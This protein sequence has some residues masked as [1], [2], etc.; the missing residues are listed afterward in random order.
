LKAGW[1]IQEGA[2]EPFHGQPGK[3][4]KNEI[5]PS[6]PSWAKSGT[7]NAICNFGKIFILSGLSPE[8]SRKYASNDSKPFLHNHL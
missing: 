5:L 7:L 2:A 8:N 4:G 3:M 6:G 1:A